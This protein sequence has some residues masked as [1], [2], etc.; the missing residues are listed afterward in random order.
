MHPSLCVYLRQVM[1]PTPRDTRLLQSFQAHALALMSNGAAWPDGSD[2]DGSTEGAPWKP[3]CETV[4]RWAFLLSFPESM[5]W[6]HPQDWPAPYLT[7]S[8]PG[9]AREEAWLLPQGR[10][11]LP[12]TPFLALSCSIRTCSP[13]V[14]LSPAQ[15]LLWPSPLGPDPTISS[16]TV[17]TASLWSTG[18]LSSPILTPNRPLTPA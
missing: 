5:A 3:D 11:A 9:P 17:V 1:G 6:P 12:L 7:L 14:C 8:K 4:R 10:L 13:S 16:W 2:Y 18:P 15:P